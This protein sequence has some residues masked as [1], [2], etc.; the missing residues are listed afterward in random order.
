MIPGNKATSAESFATV[1]I[2]ENRRIREGIL[3]NLL[4]KTVYMS[5]DWYILLLMMKYACKVRAMERT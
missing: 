2:R 4:D 1:S 5:G 3:A